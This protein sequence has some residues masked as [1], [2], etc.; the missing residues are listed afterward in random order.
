MKVNGVNPSKII[1]LYSIRNKSSVQEKS[2]I[3]NQDKIEISDIGKSLSYFS[4]LE[5]LIPDEKKVQ[6]I[7]MQIKNGSYKLESRKVAEALMKF[8]RGKGI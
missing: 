2:S 4:D 3:K 7:K 1:N 5:E 6:D 8:V